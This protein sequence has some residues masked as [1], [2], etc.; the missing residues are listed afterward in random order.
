MGTTFYIAA[1]VAIFSTAMV[2]TRL[3]AVHALLYLVV[4]LLSVALVFLSLG[5][6]FIAALEVIV[7]AG[8]IMVLF[9][10]VIMML[11]LG[12]AAAAQEASW[13]RPGIW[14]GPAALCVLLL[15][16]LIYVLSRGETAQKVSGALVVGPKQVAI[17]LYGP[18]LLGVELA[19]MLLLAGLVG[20]YHLGR[21]GTDRDSGHGRGGGE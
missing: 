11:N 9:L 4:S 15:I 21:R 6:P 7:Y 8:V 12:K 1:A 10:F 16:E 3:S 17:V 20:A 2:I 19:S 5:A 14:G 18:Y 13:L